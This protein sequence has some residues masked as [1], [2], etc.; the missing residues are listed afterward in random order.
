ML[1]QQV[2][3]PA[4]I[5]HRNHLQEQILFLFV[6]HSLCRSDNSRFLVS[7][8]KGF[9]NFVHNCFG[10]PRTRSSRPAVSTSDGSSS[11]LLYSE[12]LAMAKKVDIVK[13]M[14]T[15][16]TGRL[17]RTGPLEMGC[18]NS[19]GMG[20]RP[21]QPAGPWNTPSPPTAGAAAA[22]SAHVPPPLAANNSHPPLERQL[23]INPTFDPRINKPRKS[24]QQPV[25]YS[26]AME[27]MHRNPPPPLGSMP[28]GPPPN[29]TLHHHRQ[30]PDHHQNVTRIASAPDSIRLWGAAV[31]S[32]GGGAPSSSS[33]SLP[34]AIV[35]PL[36]MDLLAAAGVAA[37]RSPIIQRRHNSTSDSQLNRNSPTTTTVDPF[38]SDTWKYDSSVGISPILSA[39]PVGGSS[40]G[41]NSTVA[42]NNI[43]GPPPPTVAASSSSGTALT[44]PRRESPPPSP[45][46]L[47][48]VGSSR[49][50]RQQDSRQQLQYHLSALFP[51][52]QVGAAPPPTHR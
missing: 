46:K 33:S 6:L 38:S 34:V 41:G 15:D 35:E 9:V 10:Y 14:S 37:A 16:T 2:V 36:G 50:S 26:A 49:P 32:G 47:G 42:G 43:W 13:S 24:Q 44:P 11:S 20:A 1:C 28:S 5:Y 31:N 52:D 8:Y 17:W 29:Q 12:P 25:F 21:P 39:S 48:P 45:L 40:S 22:F 30:L 18:L 7:Y 23:T 4:K 19:Y 27:Y 51:S 3:G